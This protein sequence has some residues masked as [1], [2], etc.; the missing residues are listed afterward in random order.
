MK[1]IILCLT[2]GF[3]M[4]AVFKTFHLP[5]PSPPIFAGVMGIVGV[6]FGGKFIDWV[7]LFIKIGG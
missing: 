7:Q 3:V 1:E 6:Y 4:G 2:A 5:S